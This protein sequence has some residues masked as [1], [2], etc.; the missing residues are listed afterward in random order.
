ML[1]IEGK[2]L[3]DYSVESFS[4][5]F[6][7]ELFLFII[8]DVYGTKKFVEERIAALAIKNFTI[9]TVRGET[10]GQAET[11]NLGLSECRGFKGSIT[12]FNIDTFRPGFTFPTKNDLGDGYL[13]VFKGEGANWSYVRPVQNQGTEIDL[14]REKQPISDLCCTGVYN[15]SNVEDFTASFEHYTSMPKEFWEK[16]ELYVAPLY[17]YLISLGKKLTIT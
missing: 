8:R 2:T 11:V 16:G 3:F 13:E 9:V 7:S 10:R 15:F 4:N 14:V 5:Y 6:S 17:N 1:E 12:I